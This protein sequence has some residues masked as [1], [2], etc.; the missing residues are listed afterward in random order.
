MTLKKSRAWYYFSKYIKARDGEKCFI[1]GRIA[2][3]KGLHAG[4]F[5]QAFGNQ[6]TFFEETNVH[7]SCYNCNINKYGNLL[8]YRRKIIE[9]YGVGYDEELERRGR[10][11]KQWSKRELKEIANTYKQKLLEL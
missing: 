10:Q 9:K 3:G 11:H 4:H 5:V 1:C 7:S 2:S 6:N 8:E